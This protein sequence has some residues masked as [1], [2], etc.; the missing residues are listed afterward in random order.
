[1]IQ[2]IEDILKAFSKEISLNGWSIEGFDLSYVDNKEN[3]I[4][5]FS[6]S[7]EMYFN[8]VSTGFTNPE[9]GSLLQSENTFQN[10]HIESIY[11]IISNKECSEIEN[12]KF[13]SYS[14]FFSDK[15]NNAEHSKWIEHYKKLGLSGVYFSK[16]K[17]RKRDFDL[18]LFGV[19]KGDD[20]KS[21]LK[22]LPVIVES[23]TEK[24]L[25]DFAI[26]F[27][28]LRQ[29][30]KSVIEQATRAAISQVMARNT[31]HN[32]GAHVMNKLIGDLNYDSLFKK[33]NYVSAE[34]KTLYT[35]TIKKWN[36]DRQKEKKPELTE[37]EQ[38]QKILLDQISIFNNYVKCRMDYLADISFGTP[39]MQTNKYAYGELFTE[40]DK[41]RLLLEHIS[42]L[43]NFKFKIEFKRNGK[44]FEKDEK[45]NICNDLLVAIPNDILG[46]QAFYNILENII[47]NSAKHSDKSK[48]KPGDDVVFTINFINDVSKVDGYCNDDQCDRTV[49]GKAHK[50]EIENALNEFIAVEVYD[51]I[52]VERTENEIKLNDKELS[53]Y[54]RMMGNKAPKINTPI[55]YL[56]FNQNKKLNEDIL[57]ENK[58]RSY[59]LGLV[60]MDASAAYLRKRPV[61]YINHRSYDIQYDESWSRNTELNAK[62]D[63]KNLTTEEREQ[64]K[65][66]KRGSNCR[67]FLKAFKK[68]VE[69]TKEGKKQIENYL[70]YR[71]F[72]HR[73]AV[74]LVVTELLKDEKERERREKLKKKGIWVVTKEEF[75]KEL[76]EGKVYPHEF[77]IHTGLQDY[78][79]VTK[80]EEPKV[81]LLNY[82]KTS[83]PLR[84]I[85]IPNEDLGSILKNDAENIVSDCWSKWFEKLRDKN[86][87]SNH[88][89]N[90]SNRFYSIKG[91]YNQDTCHSIVLIDHLYKDDGSPDIEK[92]NEIWACLEKKNC[93]AEAL[94][95]LAQ[96]KLPNY[97]KIANQNC[98]YEVSGKRMLQCYLRNIYELVK[99]QIA[100]SAFTKVVV[101]DERIQEASE[102]RDFLTI[103]FDRL[104]QKM[105]VIVPNKDDINLSA[106]SYDIALINKLKQYLG[107]SINED[108]M[109]SNIQD[110][111]IGLS[112]NDFILIHYSI[113]ERMFK[114]EE[115]NGK[116]EEI[117][118]KGINV[119]VTSGRGTPENLTTKARFINLSSVINAFVDVRSKYLINYLL[120]S[121]RKSNK[122]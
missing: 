35:E 77:V 48:L 29:N 97:Y 113:F 49:C 50:K 61:E 118:Q 51:N 84:V 82:F 90:H 45:G 98:K 119:V 53:E 107:F 44:E 27:E 2:E 14:G 1:M 11:Q 83:L 85:E 13:R 57:Q 105:N 19:I 88:T 39:L 115:I 9:L 46:T 52:P 23:F 93:H 3:H 111:T 67:H 103:K 79:T 24:N 38:H 30:R 63:D 66:E 16:G 116:L 26:V 72:L 92:A 110:I 34:L 40:F 78:E 41:V 55:H 75:E 108:D 37:E 5:I 47:R 117:T 106:S 25:N 36:Q 62:S 65:I 70:G 74:V 12:C 56:V 80:N 121:S 114:K 76:K 89:S 100:E 10:S 20:P 69:V 15:N 21:I 112:D 60:E 122:I 120:N 86:Q 6:Y 31:S 17:R 94:S 28:N 81:N 73:P 18:V 32:I 96:S 8:A 58:L 33:N 4:E 42:G 91:T 7:S 104:Y 22:N 109:N 102:S 71:F 87:C 68:T 99:Q 59:S 101:V 43:D 95:S 54:K 64:L